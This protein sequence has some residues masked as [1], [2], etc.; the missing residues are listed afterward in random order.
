MPRALKPMKV[1]EVHHPNLHIR[2]D[3]MLD[4]NSNTFFVE[5]AG[6]KISDKT[7]E[8]CSH[9]AYKFIETNAT[10]KFQQI[11]VVNRLQ[12]FCRDGAAFVGMEFDRHEVAHCDY[13]APGWGKGSWVERP[14][15]PKGGTPNTDF[16]ML[17]HYGGATPQEPDKIDFNLETNSARQAVMPYSEEAWTALEILEQ[18]IRRATKQ[19]DEL[20]CSKDLEIKLKLISSGNILALPPKEESES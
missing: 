14:W 5:Y 2:V 15:T 16:T 6:Q 4:R 3:V 9:A 8:G 19:L 17:R 10:L 20:M 13:S 12:P 11:I 1:G 7:A 18:N